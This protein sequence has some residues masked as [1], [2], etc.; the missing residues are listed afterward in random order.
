[1]ESAQLKRESARLECEVALLGGLTL[2]PC[3][4]PVFAIGLNWSEA[5]LCR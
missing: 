5:L 2:Y 3:S 1:M 4:V